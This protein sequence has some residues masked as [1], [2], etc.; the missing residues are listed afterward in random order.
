MKCY[1]FVDVYFLN[2]ILIAVPINGTNVVLVY[3]TF[4]KKFSFIVKCF[5]SLLIVNQKWY[6]LLKI[7][8]Y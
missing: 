7:N 6:L 5:M 2:N 1:Y 8:P 3:F 4:K